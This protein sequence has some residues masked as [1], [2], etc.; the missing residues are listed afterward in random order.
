M[1]PGYQIVELCLGDLVCHGVLV[2][3]EIVIQLREEGLGV[4]AGVDGWWKTVD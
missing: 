1:Q 4:A 2:I 3:R